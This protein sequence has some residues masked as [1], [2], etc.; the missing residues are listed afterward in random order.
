MANKCNGEAEQNEAENS[1][2]TSQTYF[3]QLQRMYDLYVD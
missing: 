2:F 3:V 1:I